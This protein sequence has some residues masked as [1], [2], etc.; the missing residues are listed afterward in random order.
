VKADG[1]A[2]GPANGTRNGRGDNG[3]TGPALACDVTV[4]YDGVAVARDLSVTVGHGEIL[5]VLGPNGAGKTTLLLTLSGLL[6][7]ISGQI[8]VDGSRVRAGSARRMN[9]L[10]VVLVPDNRALF[11][12]LTTLENLRV[13]KRA[14]PRRGR[15]VD[16]VL[17]L[18]PVLRK[19]ANLK[20]GMLS[21]GEQ[22]MLAL[23]RALVQAPRVL[24]VDEMSMGLAPVIVEGLMPL[25]RTIADT[26]GAAVVL[27]EQHAQL[28]LEVADQALVLVHGEVSL[29]APAAQ[30]LQ[31]RDR[32]EQAY[33][34][35]G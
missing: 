25:V 3:A 8:E 14:S 11:T 4:G 34:G 13:A 31:D 35:A 32:L 20:A 21:G 22:Q 10:G 1:S 29:R 30:L 27:V 15:T 6:P 17:D 23:G 33:L 12:Q 28:A 18:F 19:R 2:D 5:A 16:D 7:P 9:Q 26:T 24:L